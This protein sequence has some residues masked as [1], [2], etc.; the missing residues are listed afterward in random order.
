MMCLLYFFQSFELF[1]NNDIRINIYYH[2]GTK[3]PFDVDCVETF[4]CR[5]RDIGDE[6]TC[7][8]IDPLL[9]RYNNQC[10]S[11][12][13]SNNCK[14]YYY[15]RITDLIDNIT[16][17]SRASDDREFIQKL[18]EISEYG[19]DGSNLVNSINRMINNNKMKLPENMNI[20]SLYGNNSI[21]RRTTISSADEDQYRIYLDIDRIITKYGY[22][23]AHDLENSEIVGQAQVVAAI[24]APEPEKLRTTQLVISYDIVQKELSIDML[25][26]LK[27]E[28]VS[29]Y[30]KLVYENTSRGDLQQ[31][32]PTVGN[33]NNDND[34]NNA[35]E[36]D[37]QN[38]CKGFPE[39]SCGDVLDPIKNPDKLVVGINYPLISYC[40]SPENDPEDCDPINDWYE[41]CKGGI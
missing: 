32:M 16:E 1:D 23:F 2:Y 37:L 25:F 38:L 6:G 18:N 21:P 7:H 22:C 31:W 20:A 27:Q 4:Q 19:G 9:C 41:K 33:T 3:D 39:L 5:G 29:R 13:T 10:K 12:N 28:L 14:D 36:R 34:D 11:E 35:L 24:P 30:N 8:N 15:I 40:N 17:K 26:S